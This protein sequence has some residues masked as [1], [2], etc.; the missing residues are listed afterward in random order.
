MHAFSA[1]TSP[2]PTAAAAA[3]SAAIRRR[4]APTSV[5]GT[6]L[7]M[8]N[9]RGPEIF[10]QSATRHKQAIIIDILCTAHS[11]NLAEGI[12][13]RRRFVEEQQ[14]PPLKRSATKAKTHQT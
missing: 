12:E 3:V 1:S 6:H 5:A 4:A 13:E 10:A 14:P 11:L 7:V 2:A 9:T 8:R